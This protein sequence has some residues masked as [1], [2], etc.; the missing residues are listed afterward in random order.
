MPEE[1]TRLDSFTRRLPTFLFFVVLLLAARQRLAWITEVGMMG[2]DGFRYMEAAH[3]WAGGNY[4]HF[5]NGYYR[6]GYY[7][8]GALAV[9]LFGYHDYTLKLLSV[10]SDLVNI[11]L[12]YRLGVMLIG[13]RVLALIPV[14]LYASLL[15]VVFIARGE[16]PHMV[17]ETTVLLTLIA[18]IHSVRMFRAGR[19]SAWMWLGLAGLGAG[20]G[21]NIHPDVAFLGPGY[22]ACLGLTAWLDGRG[23][24][25]P[26]L[27]LVLRCAL[28]TSAFFLPYLLGVLV[29]GWVLI[30]ELYENDGRLMRD[31]TV[32]FNKA[33]DVALPFHIFHVVSRPLFHFTGSLLPK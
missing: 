18:F 28:F 6:P 25:R 23:R 8:L 7:L 20:V 13:G 15:D 4:H 17:T 3:Q 29:Y 2:G 32:Q 22:I 12:I 21:S 1:R 14:L 5:M 24:P 10:L 26:L 31:Y 9:K 19:R 33:T 16:M 27:T 30:W 11:C